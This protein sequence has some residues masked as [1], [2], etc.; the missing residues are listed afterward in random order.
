MLHPKQRGFLNGD[1]EPDNHSSYQQ[2]SLH[3]NFRS[4]GTP[5]ICDS[6][7]DSSSD[8]FFGS[9][10]RLRNE[11]WGRREGLIAVRR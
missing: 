10:G 4:V 5:A 11:D 6:R 7:M 9:L 3:G 8:L 2:S 1:Q